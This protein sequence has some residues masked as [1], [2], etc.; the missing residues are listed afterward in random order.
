MK[1]ISV[2]IPLYNNEPFL[3]RCL[4]SVL[5]QTYQN[6]E[7]LVID[8]G[9]TDQGPAL[10]QTFAQRDSRIT[11]FRQEHRGVSAARNRGLD[12]AAW[13]AVFFLDSDDIIHP[14]L[15]EESVRQLEEDRAQLT[16]C[17]YRR[18]DSRQLERLILSPDGEGPRW[19]YTRH[20]ESWFH[21]TYSNDLSGIGGKLIRRDLIGSLRFDESLSNGEDTLFLYQLF[22]QGPRV[23][24]CSR[25]WYYYRIH[26]G[27]TTHGSAALRGERSFQAARQIRDQEWSRG[28]RET[29]LVWERI[30]LRQLETSLAALS[31]TGCWEDLNRVWTAAKKERAH[32]LYREL[33]ISQ[34]FQFSASRLGSWPYRLAK[35]LAQ[36]LS[37]WK[38]R[39]I[40][41]VGPDKTGILTFHCS[42]NFGAMLQAYALK[43]FLTEQG[44]SAGL[45]PYAPFYMTGRHWLFPYAPGLWKKNP[46]LG[47]GYLLWG[48]LTNLRQDGDFFRRREAMGRFRET[49]LVNKD[50]PLLR[51]CLRFGRLPY[52]C[53]VLGSDQIWNPE[54]TF[55]LRRAYFGAFESAR[56]QRVVAYAAS[57]GGGSL[58]EKY[59]EAFTELL[60]HMDAVSLREE[61]AVPYVR[62]CY[63]GPVTTVVDPVLLL[64]R[65]EWML[66]ERPPERES[67]ILVY[68]TERNPELVAFAAELS[69][70]TGLPVLELGSKTLAW[71]SGFQSDFT[72]G[73]AEFLGYIHKA[74]YVLSNSFH[75]TAF[76]ILYQK[77]FLIYSHSRF[78]AR[79][80]TLLRMHGLEDRLVFPG[81]TADIDAP[82]DWAAVAGRTRENV[83]RS[84]DFLRQNIPDLLEDEAG[85]E[86]EV[87]G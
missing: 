49:Y 55:G 56:K 85:G 23:A 84:G 59:D 11:L 47:A 8:D 68:L 70:R 30:A 67:Y 39:L 66:V 34:R 42:D 45:V 48:A 15:L 2:I 44:I 1:R 62:R 43:T 9:S 57:L 51:T 46:F 25:A 75:A 80:Q 38:R 78:G 10:C 26:S 63:Q 76:S 16:F 60:R 73:P 21:E 65:W 86:Q 6:F 64:E 37:R 19:R 36:F 13:D 83:R 54:I 58:P 87:R 72:A 24:R 33:C 3:A 20:G 82:I 35:G 27:S 69:Q 32:P 50:T 79:I 28:R 71:G 77:R 14:L 53:Y 4:Q 52:R 81:G 29:A 31:G 7:V 18:A 61:E 41:D 74:D 12:Q 17:P 40:V 22:L 5:D